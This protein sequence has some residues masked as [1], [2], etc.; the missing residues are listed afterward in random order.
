MGEV[1]RSEIIESKRESRREKRVGGGS[2][3]EKK[4]FNGE[5]PGESGWS[6]IH[7]DARG[8]R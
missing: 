8:L 4:S 1:E 7:M 6:Y 3:E 2:G 5:K